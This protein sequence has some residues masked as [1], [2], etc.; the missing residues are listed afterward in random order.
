[1][2][3]VDDRAARSDVRQDR[4]ADA[5]PLV[6]QAEVAEKC[7]LSG[8]RRHSGRSIPFAGPRCNRRRAKSELPP[9]RDQAVAFVCHSR[10]E[11]GARLREPATDPGEV[12]SVR[13]PRVRVFELERD[14]FQTVAFELDQKEQA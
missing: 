7:D 11:G 12:V 10:A 14:R 5:D 6:A 8:L 13:K 3:E 2:R 9:G 1:M 4:M